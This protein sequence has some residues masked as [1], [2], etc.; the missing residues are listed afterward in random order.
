MLRFSRARKGQEEIASFFAFLVF[1]AVAAII[2]GVLSFNSGTIEQKISG[3]FG[4]TDLRE[5]LLTF[6]M[7]PNQSGQNMADIIAGM[8]NKPDAGKNPDDTLLRYFIN[9][10]FDYFEYD[11]NLAYIIAI[12]DSEKDEVY[13]LLD[14]KERFD[15][16][17]KYFP[18]YFHRIGH[19]PEDMNG[20]NIYIPNPEGTIKNIQ[21]SLFKVELP[22]EIKFEK[23][24]T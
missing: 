18:I 3:E 23:V 11:P 21:V 22:E 14:N 9:A 6:L 5:A 1:A 10:T 8:M 12:G 24:E 2:F 17:N 7:T 13:Y 15:E 16:K 20:V 4:D 19:F